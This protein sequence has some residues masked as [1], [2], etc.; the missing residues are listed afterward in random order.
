MAG[1]TRPLLPLS[2]SDTK[3][4][5]GHSNEYLLDRK[6]A[7]QSFPESFVRWLARARDSGV[8][9]KPIDW[10]ELIGDAP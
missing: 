10:A 9:D 1:T 2:I 5:R 6:Q 4:A 8:V 3:I 7:A